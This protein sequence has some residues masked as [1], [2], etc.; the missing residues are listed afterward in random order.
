MLEQRIKTLISDIN[1]IE[2]AKYIM[3]ETHI[4]T[5][6]DEYRIIEMEL[7]ICNDKHKD[8]FTH[9]HSMQKTMLNWYFHQMSEKSGSYKGGTFKGLDISC[10]FDEGYGGILIR[11]V[12][13]ES[14]NQVI[15]GPCNVVNELLK[16]TKSQ[17]ISDFVSKSNANISCIN[18]D[19]LKLEEKKFIDESI[20]V[21]PRIGLSLKGDNIEEKKQYVDRKYRYIIFKDKIKKEKK[22]LE[23]YKKD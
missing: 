17:S 21:A 8:I 2:L 18:N 7:Y 5:N 14:T 3:L 13:N 22:K 1:F 6:N 16:S 15:E 20:Y 19:L 9:Q 4:K 12:L 23:L 10:G 11:A